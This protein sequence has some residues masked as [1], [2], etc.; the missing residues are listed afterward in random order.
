[1][2]LPVRTEQWT[3]QQVDEAKKAAANSLN[4]AAEE[5]GYESNGAVGID[6][7]VGITRARRLRSAATEDLDMVPNAA[8]L[9]L[10]PAE[11]FEAWLTRIHAEREKVHGP[12]ILKSLEGA[13][14]AALRA[15]AKVSEV[16][17]A[18]LEDGTVDDTEIP[19]IERALDESDV[20]RA[21]VRGMLRRR[22]RR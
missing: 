8:Q 7:G 18:A 15:D 9:I 1:M 4:T 17:L 20:R 10:A 5:V 13:M 6:I 12:R 14:L 19:G 11:L 16:K 2:N 21:E 22:S 3:D